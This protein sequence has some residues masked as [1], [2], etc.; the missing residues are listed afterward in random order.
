MAAAIQ[1]EINQALNAL[2]ESDPYEVNNFTFN[3]EKYS[4][5]PAHLQRSIELVGEKNLIVP[6]LKVKKLFFEAY[7][8]TRLLSESDKFEVS[9]RDSL[10][11]VAHIL[12]EKAIAME[13]TA[14]WLYYENAF[15]YSFRTPSP[16][17]FVM[18]YSEAALEHSPNWL[19][20]MLTFAN[21][22]LYNLHDYSK[23]ELW[24][25]KAKKVNP[26]SFV[27]LERL[28]WLY[29]TV[30]PKDKAMEMA[31][32]M[33]AIRPD[34]FNGYGT[35]GGNYF[36]LFDFTE[37]KKWYQKAVEK[38]NDPSIWVQYYLGYEQ[39]AKG[40]TEKGRM[41]FDKMLAN[42]RTPY[43]MAANYDTWYAKGLINFTKE[44]P[45][46]EQLLDSALERRHIPYD[47]AEVFIWQAK[48]KFLQNQLAESRQLLDRAMAY[49]SLNIS[50]FIL[51]YSLMGELEAAAGND[52]AAETLFIKSVNYP[53]DDFFKE[54]A[55]YRY[56]VFLLG[57]NRMDE[58]EKQFQL[59]QYIT[60]N[61][62]F[63]GGIW[64]STPQCQTREKRP[65]L[66]PTRQ[67]I[68][69]IFPIL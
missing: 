42:E 22:Y 18:K 10:R 56:G 50:A 11:K 51:G 37:A 44:L 54:E 55:L 67:G 26:A 25:L 31:D 28:A 4:E 61:H 41:L 58:A 19:L 13:P 12:V 6:A 69:T 16:I 66:L 59:C 23:A 5:Y 9:V 52:Q 21:E 62:G 1:D 8:T 3:P 24:L 40:E 46:A 63:W 57:K 43:W 32:K 49:E 20:P 38:D 2:L 48:A 53:G 27:A 64:P 68:S 30:G 15:F 47:I 60:N 14:A 7:N 34:L 17:D 33:I 29:Q 65:S 36:Q 39:M 35:K 45:R